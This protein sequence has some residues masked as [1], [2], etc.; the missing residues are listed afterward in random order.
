MEYEEW[1]KLRPDSKVYHPE[2]VPGAVY[3][4][5]I[6]TNRNTG[7]SHQYGS[8][9][10]DP[11]TRDRLFLPWGYG[12]S[13]GRFQ[14]TNDHGPEF[15]AFGNFRSHWYPKRDLSVIEITGVA[16]KDHK[17]LSRSEFD[18]SRI[19]RLFRAHTDA[20]S[21]HH[22]RSKLAPRSIE[23]IVVDTRPEFP[24]SDSTNPGE[25]DR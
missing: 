12:A 25:D 17:K 15:I 3:E 2:P 10:I 22:R 14:L 18:A 4:P 1:L 9:V 6:S 20:S 8:K 16:T 21:E 7:Q 19:A 11:A 24:P 13:V 5:M 23:V